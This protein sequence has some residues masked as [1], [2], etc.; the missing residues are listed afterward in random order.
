MNRN[1]SII[2]AFFVIGLVLGIGLIVSGNQ[3][4]K[5]SE[6]LHGWHQVSTGI[7]MEQAGARA[8]EI[9]SQQSSDEAAYKPSG[10]TKR[11]IGI[12]I[13]CAS[14]LFFVVSASIYVGTRFRDHSNPPDKA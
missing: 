8:T 13:V 3:D 11:N 14:S 6:L 5:S 2:I 7:R 10:G 1:V 4:E 12:V 9:R